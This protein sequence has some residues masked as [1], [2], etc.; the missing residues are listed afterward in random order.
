MKILV[1]VREVRVEVG[2]LPYSNTMGEGK[3]ELGRSL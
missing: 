3:E 2:V 1:H